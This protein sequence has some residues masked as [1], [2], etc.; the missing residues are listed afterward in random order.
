MGLPIGRHPLAKDA[1]QLWTVKNGVKSSQAQV[2]PI[3]ESS[4]EPKVALVVPSVVDN[5]RLSK[6]L[7][8]PI[9]RTM[10]MAKINATDSHPVTQSMFVFID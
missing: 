4:E 2:C 9:A 10:T 5:K 7:V 1:P 3:M 6:A 8:V